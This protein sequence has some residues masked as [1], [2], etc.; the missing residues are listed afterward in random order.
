MVCV[1][2]CGGLELLAPVPICSYVSPRHRQALTHRRG[3]WLVGDNPLMVGY[4]AIT[5]LEIH[6][7][8]DMVPGPTRT[9]NPQPAVVLSLFYVP[10]NPCSWPRG[11]SEPLTSFIC[12]FDSG[13]LA[14]SYG[15][16]QTDPS[17]STVVSYGGRP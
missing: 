17:R 8:Q 4:D 12:V 3:S 7:Q 15:S 11:Q 13:H 1:D 14:A 5:K 16:P 10:A 6:A 9:A 2:V